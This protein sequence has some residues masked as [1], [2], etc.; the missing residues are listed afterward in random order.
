[1]NLG[2]VKNVDFEFGPLY[3]AVYKANHDTKNLG[4]L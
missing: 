3:H 1:V 4:H 2:N